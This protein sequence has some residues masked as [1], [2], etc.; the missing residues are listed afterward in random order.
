MRLLTLLLFTLLCTCG[1]AQKM[2]IDTVAGPVPGYTTVRYITEMPAEAEMSKKERFMR[3][4]RGASEKTA[5]DRLDSIAVFDEM[6]VRV[7]A[8]DLLPP[9]TS[10]PDDTPYFAEHIVHLDGRIGELVATT[11]RVDNPREEGI[12]LKRTDAEDALRTE[13]KILTVPGHGSAELAVEAELAEGSVT[14]AIVMSDAEKTF[15]ELRVV[16]N[17][18]DLNE[19]D[20][21]TSRNDA[22]VWEVPAGRETLYLRLR[23]TEK[24]MTIYKDGR[25]YSKVA[26]G[27]QLDELNLSGLGV[28]EYQLEV[29]DLGTGQRRYHGLR[30]AR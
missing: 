22:P 21:T 27:R 30:R 7:P 17:G 20:F 18:Y 14:H 3:G 10:L 11:L 4:I 16:L 9:S 1:R 12:V 19:Q 5:W 24:L 8:R 2:R 23:S 26:V 15:L 29:I 13:R 25:V 6:G 28:G